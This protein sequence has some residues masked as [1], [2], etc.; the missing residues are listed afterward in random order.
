MESEQVIKSQVQ[1]QQPA[2]KTNESVT[3]KIKDYKQVLPLSSKAHRL[4]KTKSLVDCLL[5]FETIYENQNLIQSNS[6][7]EE[8]FELANLH[9]NT[10]EDNNDEKQFLNLYLFGNRKS[11]IKL[12]DIE[13]EELKSTDQVSISNYFWLFDVWKGNIEKLMTEIDSYNLVNDFFFTIYQ[14]SIT[15]SIYQ[16]NKF[17]DNYLRQ[18]LTNNEFH[19]V[20]I[21]YIV[22][23][24]INEAIEL[25]LE[26]NQYQFALCLAQL[27]LD[28][29]IPEDNCLFK[30]V[31]FKYA[32]YSTQNGDYET[33]VLAYMRIKDLQNAS[34]S[35][36]RRI[37]ANE[38]QKLLIQNL[39]NK[40]SKHDPS[41][42]LNNNET[43]FEN[44]PTNEQ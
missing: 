39:T 44:E 22:S 23:Y 40:F 38:E 13:Y 35:I 1:F 28:K 25:Y 9:F 14:I 11:T 8:Q 26:H 3:L 21:Y 32:N 6:N 20:A 10:K 17:F 19:K 30:K 27:R 42:C 36:T 5:L 33:A 24:R 37:A 12:L 29:T 41:I 7:F 15:P 4:S 34:K 2:K 43:I 16:E 18:L 31:L